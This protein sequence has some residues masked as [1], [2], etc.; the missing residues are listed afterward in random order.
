MKRT[1]LTVLCALVALCWFG[2]AEPA[3]AWR[4]GPDTDTGVN[5]ATPIQLDGSGQ[6]QPLL[7]DREERGSRGIGLQIIPLILIIPLGWLFFRSM[8]RRRNDSD[9]E[10]QQGNESSPRPD[11]YSREEDPENL[12]E[13]YRRARAQWE[14]MTSD[15]KAGAEP[16][17]A[18]GRGPAVDGFDEKDF[19]K[20][21]KLV[22]ARLTEAFDN[23]DAEAAAPF[24]GESVLE[25]LRA[26]AASGVRPLS[27]EIVLVNAELLEHDHKDDLEKAVVLYDAL[28]RRG[29]DAAEPE[30]LKQIWRFTRDPRDPSSMWRLERMEAYSDPNS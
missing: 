4:L 11:S 14:W 30:Q 22:Y 17:T 25:G 20:G 3:S 29:P 23:L 13:A 27:T 18:T 12:Q 2:V 6:D 7:A 8:S 19:L 10:E 16:K 9:G 5:A 24:A 26:R 15:P 1:W 21:A 28:I